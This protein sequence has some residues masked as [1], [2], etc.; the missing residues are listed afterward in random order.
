M[1]LQHFL[2]ASSVPSVPPVPYYIRGH[3]ILPACECAKCAMCPSTYPSAAEG[4]REYVDQ[5][6]LNIQKAV[7]GDPENML[8]STSN[9][10]LRIETVITIPI[11]SFCFF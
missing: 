9:S 7:A 4:F 3:A 6:S 10:I 1:A 8:F 5:F 11:A 2:T